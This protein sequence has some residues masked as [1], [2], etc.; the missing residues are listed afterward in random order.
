MTFLSLAV[1]RA[2]SLTSLPLACSPGY[3]IWHKYSRLDLSTNHSQGLTKCCLAVL[4]FAIGNWCFIQLTVVILLL[5]V[6][7]PG[8]ILS[9]ERSLI[10]RE[11]SQERFWRAFLA[12]NFSEMSHRY[13]FAE[14][15]SRAS[16]GSRTNRRRVTVKVCMLDDSVVK[17]DLEVRV[18]QSKHFA[19][20]AN[21][22]GLLLL[23][24]FIAF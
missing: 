23:L 19:Q 1:P 16:R 11:T 15:D 14:Q 22:C 6:H 4:M 21:N 8:C 10:E 9:C 7:S 5:H 2:I 20:G 13:D 3:L 18:F 24:W 17:F 12:E